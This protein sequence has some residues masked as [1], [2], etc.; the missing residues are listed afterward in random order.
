MECRILSSLNRRQLQQPLASLWAKLGFS[1]PLIFE[2]LTNRALGKKRRFSIG[3]DNSAESFDKENLNPNPKSRGNTPKKRRNSIVD[4]RTD[5][6]IPFSLGD[7]VLTSDTSP[8]YYTVRNLLEHLVETQ[9][10]TLFLY[11]SIR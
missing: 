3:K 1:K 9:G 7:A 10:L 11:E 4:P 6:P 8:N 5:K 2:A